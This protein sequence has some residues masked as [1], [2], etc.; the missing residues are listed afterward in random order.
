[1]SAGLPGFSQSS[2]WILESLFP[3]FMPDTFVSCCH[4]V[5]PP[6]A[7]LEDPSLFFSAP[8]CRTLLVNVT[9]LSFLSLQADTTNFGWMTAKS[10]QSSPPTFGLSCLPSH[11]CDPVGLN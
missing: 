5:L 9:K 2:R 1:L 7:V 8:N 3:V 6:A 4:M 10:L 11:E